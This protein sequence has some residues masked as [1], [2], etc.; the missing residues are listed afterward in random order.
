MGSDKC[1][2]GG[3]PKGRE[4]R[5]GSRGPAGD[6]EVGGES[7]PRRLPRE[8]DA[9]YGC[10]ECV[11]VSWRIKSRVSRRTQAWGL[12][13]QVFFPTLHCRILYLSAA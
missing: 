1:Q 13:A 6:G 2:S 4:S 8:G 12:P 3:E 5:E 10:E 9:W 7:D 11:G